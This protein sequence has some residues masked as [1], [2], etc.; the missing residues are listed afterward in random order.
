MR[1]LTRKEKLTSQVTLAFLTG[2]FSMIPAAFG[3]PTG[4]DIKFG[5]V[6]IGTPGT[7]ATDGKYTLPITSNSDNNVIAWEGFSVGAGEKVQFDGGDT[8][9]EH[10]YMN[11]VTGDTSSQIDGF[12]KGGKDVYIINP[13]G[14]I[15]NEGSQVNVGSLYVSTRAVNVADAINA[16]T[17]GDM[18][19]VLSTKP[20]SNVMVADVVNLGTIHA[21]KVAMEGANIRIQNT[22]DIKLIDDSTTLLGDVTLATPNGGYVHVGY[23]YDPD[24]AKEAKDAVVIAAKDAKAA[25]TAAAAAAD[26]A[27]SVA[28][29]AEAVAAADGAT[30]DQKTAAEEAR[31]TANALKEQ[32]V[33]AANAA[34][35]AEAAVDSSETAEAIKTAGKRKRA[36]VLGYKDGSSLWNTEATSVAKVLD[37]RLVS[38]VA[39]LNAMSS[40]SS[41]NYM[42]KND[43]DFSSAENSETTFKP[44]TNF[45][46]NFDG[47]FHTINNMSVS[48]SDN[49]GLFADVSG[50]RLENVGFVNANVAQHDTKNTGSGVLAGQASGETIR[51][52][53]VTKGTVSG[54]TPEYVGG[55]VGVARGATKISS[56]Y[57]SNSYSKGGGLVGNGYVDGGTPQLENVYLNNVTK[58]ATDSTADGFFLY[59]SLKITNAYNNLNALGKSPTA[60]SSGILYGSSSVTKNLSTYKDNKWS[61]TNTGGIIKTYNYDT[62]GNKTSIKSMS[63]PVWRIYEGQTLPLL[64]AFFK[65]TVGV[66]YN[67][68]LT[69]TDPETGEKIYE[70]IQTGGSDVSRTYDKRA[71]SVNGLNGQNFSHALSETEFNEHIKTADSKT[72]VVDSGAMIYSDQQG[73]DIVGGNVTINKRKVYANITSSGIPLIKEYDGSA[74][75]TINSANA[76]SADENSET[77]I[78]KGDEGAFDI[79]GAITETF[80]KDYNE[81]DS[82]WDEEEKEDHYAPNAGTGKYVY[83]S[84][85]NF[86]IELKTGNPISKNYELIGNGTDNISSWHTDGAIVPRAIV[87]SLDKVTGLNK[88]YDGT[89]NLSEADSS[90]IDGNFKF[91]VTEKLLTSD[92][93]KTSLKVTTSEV[94]A[95]DDKYASL[96]SNDKTISYK[97]IQLGFQDG[98]SLTDEQKTALLR[99]YYLTDGTNVLYYAGDGAKVSGDDVNKG[100]DFKVGDTVYVKQSDGGTLTATGT[101]DR[102]PIN[103]S[104]LQLYSGDTVKVANKIYDGKII[105]TPDTD[106]TAKVTNGLVTVDGVTDDVFF[107]MSNKNGTFYDKDW[108][109]TKNATNNTNKGAEHADYYLIAGGTDARNYKLVNDVHAEQEEEPANLW[110]G[111]TVKVYGDGRIDQRVLKLTGSSDESLPPI[112]KTYDGNENL[113]TDTQ[114]PE[115]PYLTFGKYVTYADDSDQVVEGDDV[116]WNLE[117]AYI[118]RHVKYDGGVISDKKQVNYNVTLEDVENGT[119]AGNYVLTSAAKPNNATQEL[120][121]L[122]VNRGK[123]EPATVTLLNLKKV[124]DGTTTGSNSIEIKKLNDEDKVSVTAVSATYDTK[125][126]GE[127]KDVIYEGLELDGDNKGNYKLPDNNTFNNG[128]ITRR[129]INMSD[130][131]F[132]EGT[133]DAAIASKTYDGNAA[134]TAPNETTV[135]IVPGTTAEA[136]SVGTGLIATD[137]G[138]D[139]FRLVL[140]GNGTFLGSDG[141][142]TKKATAN[143]GANYISYSVDVAGSEVGN[144]QLYNDLNPTGVA[145]SARTIALE[146]ANNVETV[147]SNGQIDKR[148]VTYTTNSN[149]EANLPV[150]EKTYDGK[151]VITT[152]NLDTLNYVVYKEGSNQLVDGDDVTKKTTGYYDTKNVLR[153]N[154]GNVISGKNLY[155]SVGLTG[156]DAG[157]YTVINDK[158]DADNGGMLLAGKGRINPQVIDTL[159]LG[160]IS[161]VY[162]GTTGLTAANK[163]ALAGSGIADEVKT[164]KNDSNIDFKDDVSLDLTDVNIAYG[165]KNVGTNTLSYVEGTFKLTGGDSG[166]Y[167]LSDSL[168]KALGNGKITPRRIKMSDLIL[169]NKTKVYDGGETYTPAVGT[170]VTINPNSYVD[171]TTAYESNDSENEYGLVK[172]GDTLDNVSFTP[173]SGTFLDANGNATKNAS[174]DGKATTAKYISYSVGVTGADAGNYMLEN[175][176]KGPGTVNLIAGQDA[177]GVISAGTITPKTVYIGVKESPTPSRVYNGT[178]NVDNAANY[179]QISDLEL[180]DSISGTVGTYDN[181]HQGTGK[182][183][184]YN[185]ITLNDGNQGDNYNILKADNSVFK[186]NSEEL[187]GSLTGYGDITPRTVYVGVNPVSKTYDGTT[188]LENPTG[189]IYFV[190]ADEN[191]GIVGGDQITNESTGS[192]D[193]KDAGSRTVNYTFKASGDE[194]TAGDYEFKRVSDHS[195]VLDPLSGTSLPGYGRIDKKPI[196]VTFDHVSKVYDGNTTVK[197]DDISDNANIDGIVPDDMGKV[198]VSSATSATYTGKDAGEYGTNGTGSEAS[199]VKYT[200]I[201]FTDSSRD[202]SNTTDWTGNYTLGTD[203]PLYGSGTIEQRIVNVVFKDGM[204][205]GLDKVYNGNQYYDG[206]D[207]KTRFDDIA[208]ASGDTGVVDGEQ[209]NIQDEYT[210]TYYLNNAENGNV[211]R[212]AD[213]NLLSREVRINPDVVVAGDNTNINNYKINMPVGSGIISP[214][215]I[216]VDLKDKDITKEYDK[217]TKVVDS[218]T[219]TTKKYAS[220]NIKFVGY[221]EGGDYTTIDP[222]TVKQSDTEI[223][224]KVAGQDVTFALTSKYNGNKDGQ[225]R[226]TGEESYVGNGLGVE[227]TLNRNN[228]NYELKQVTTSPVSDGF[229]DSSNYATGVTAATL[230]SNSGSITPRIL[231]MKQVDKTYDGTTVKVV[232]AKDLFDRI[233]DEEDSWEVTGTYQDAE[234]N[235]TSNAADSVDAE[236][237]IRSVNYGLYADVIKNPN[238]Q[239]GDGTNYTYATT[240]INPETGAES[241]GTEG[242]TISAEGVTG[243]GFIN[244]AKLTATAEQKSYSET[245]SKS[246]WVITGDVTGWADKTQEGTVEHDA[247]I[248]NFTW[249][250]GQEATSSSES[251]TTYP[252][253]AWY[254]RGGEDVTAGNYGLNYTVTQNGN[255]DSALTITHGGSVTPP[256]INPPSP[257]SPPTPGPDPSPTPGPSP[258]PTPEPT[259]TP[260]PTPGTTPTPTPTPGTT[261]TPTPTP[262]TTPTPTPGTTPTPTPGTT[263]TP[264]PISTLITD[265]IGG[266]GGAANPVAQAIGPE[267]RL[268]PNATVYVQASGD[269]EAARMD[270]TT[271]VG[272]EY[273]NEGVNYGINV[274]GQAGIVN[275]STDSAKQESYGLMDIESTDGTVNLGNGGMASISGKGSNTEE[276]ATRKEAKSSGYYSPGI[277][278]YTEDDDEYEDDEERRRRKALARKM[279]NAQ[280]GLETVNNAV[281]LGR[282]V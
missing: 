32:A 92:G 148:I 122:A 166:N 189:G 27:E 75:N 119:D 158:Y 270:A 69:K 222:N 243:A 10:N 99:N 190:A 102:A 231:T 247:Q 262:G 65:G 207:G 272:V 234:G 174:V 52:V 133:A 179:I 164:H 139:K 48:T 238:Y 107:T 85:D 28:A 115:K 104:D 273:Q 173:Q 244:R 169:S 266:E 134:Y 25:A 216:Y 255:N 130:L 197:D 42:L 98:N 227:Y 44:I 51:N 219:D 62:E 95:Y 235:P 242:G 123:I 226:L 176:V 88:E 19:T 16:A 49:A 204:S 145:D 129:T 271:Y 106:L 111:E 103:M 269:P 161:K 31:A 163:T 15:F 278:I 58:S 215:T 6:D 39:G 194:I 261:P 132:Q 213:G 275:L 151:R 83:V 113:N 168:V 136:G 195:V 209:L 236:H 77:G 71:L 23:D 251:A 276:N 206:K 64:T 68:K 162:D 180:G 96:T 250:V 212:T 33:A 57:V 225:V 221:G 45:K 224:V 47:M 211:S 73:Y 14:V 53:Y 160:G 93:S 127:G 170:T 171:S 265:I 24:A 208:G 239:L 4:A 79:S 198:S 9:H 55:I 202:T 1:T 240:M 152:L 159:T 3:M 5:T 2:M 257:P 229:V 128:V 61:I 230:T 126:V 155:L 217:T 144:Y 147:Y 22:D 135:Y 277:S 248:G 223:T 108:E 138:D 97:G 46:G 36:S 172:I 268:T 117:A 214:Q 110:N 91:D 40:E 116:S 34:T 81:T 203:G 13:N 256:P 200:G 74:V 30:D 87:V 165:D 124:Y 59:G 131:L 142:F 149:P 157:N 84:A 78:I 150:V 253:Y 252:V 259:P 109:A 181:K 281:N 167:T 246:K 21:N 182:D 143:N 280:I 82:D 112:L 17:A 67:Y 100:S 282:A 50:G 237:T 41:D 267:S 8:I 54:K 20:S 72:D 177:A 188:D 186:L 191:T 274:E 105:Y 66:D 245:T 201:M 137:V 218:P 153:D 86:S 38:D 193:Y 94:P 279:Q 187:A 241:A 254:K 183:V 220:G 178:A 11:L 37:Y 141:Q 196:T 140:N 43:I 89:T 26:N 154:A 260:T 80:Y 18:T 90:L 156:D 263:P 146:N 175:D 249:K 76:F 125:N 63:R 12:V 199:G 192:Y 264:T 29:A 185:Q 60:D 228:L 184:T 120:T 121:D 210:G 205:T 258:T 232:Q 35:S 114:S 7:D 56:S 233:I 118:D 101:I 70:T